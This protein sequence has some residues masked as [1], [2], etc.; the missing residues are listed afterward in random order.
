MKK[1][2]T[3]M[4]FISLIEYLYQKL[5]INRD[6][7]IEE[8]TLVIHIRTGD[9]FNNGWHSLYTQNPLLIFLKFLSSL[10]KSLLFVGKFTII[11]F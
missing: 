10:K 1:R 4:K 3:L 6:I 9:I 5:T 8:N 11:P 7:N 2:N